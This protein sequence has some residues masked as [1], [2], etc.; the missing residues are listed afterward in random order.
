MREDAS[1]EILTQDKIC[2]LNSAKKQKHSVLKDLRS[3]KRVLMKVRE[4]EI[5]VVIQKIGK[6][7]DFCVLRINE[8]S[9]H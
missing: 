7:E 1:D 3:V 6:K 2:D 5:K 8:A 4:R 9:Y